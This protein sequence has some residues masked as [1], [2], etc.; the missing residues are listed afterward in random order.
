MSETYITLGNLSRAMERYDSTYKI[1]TDDRIS[2]FIKAVSF[3]TEDNT[4]RFY[5]IPA[6][7]PPGTVPYLEVEIPPDADELATLFDVSLEQKVVPD[8]GK[9]RTYEFFQGTGANK[10][11]I[12]KINLEFDTVVESGVVV[13]A[14]PQNPIT[15]NG[16]QYTEGKFLRLTIKNNVEPVYIA[17]TDMG[18]L[19]QA[20]DGILIDQNNV[21]AIN[22]DTS[23]ANG[24][25]VDNNGLKLNLAVAPDQAQGI[26]GSAG[27]MSAVDKGKLDSI[28]V[29]TEAQIKALFD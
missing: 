28:N 1:Y 13:E 20:G 7:V 19:Y 24:L 27:A 10:K 18:V 29:A 21:I 12:G 26:A 16:V 22:L 9:F 2:K 4:L 25:A 8:A 23:H 3:D 17:L 14:T 6:P 15:I 5:T 11:S